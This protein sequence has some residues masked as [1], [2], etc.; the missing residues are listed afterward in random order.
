MNEREKEVRRWYARPYI[1]L[2]FSQS[3]RNNKNIEQILLERISHYNTLVMLR[4]RIFKVEPNFSY[5]YW[6]RTKPNPNIFIRT[7]TELEKVKRFKNKNKSEIL[8]YLLHY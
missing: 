5:N 7:R 1:N 6:T 2:N 3:S 4:T 8:K